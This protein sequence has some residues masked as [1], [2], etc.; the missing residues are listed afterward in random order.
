MFIDD[1]VTLYENLEYISF[2]IWMLYFFIL[3]VIILGYIYMMCT[4]EIELERRFYQRR[5]RWI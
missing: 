2:I 4:Y 5:R 1:E 3:F